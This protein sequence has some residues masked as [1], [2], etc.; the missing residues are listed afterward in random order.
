MRGQL[1]KLLFSFTIILLFLGSLL[2]TLVWYTYN[3][4]DVVVY[5]PPPQ[6]KGGAQPSGSC[7]GCREL[8]DK[9][10]KRYSIPWKK[11]ENNHQKFRTRLRNSC[12]GFEKAIITQAN[13]PVGTKINYDGEKKRS[14]QVTPE[15]FKTFIKDHPFPNKTLDTCAVVGNGGILTNSSCGNQ[16]DSAQ[17][18]IR[19]NLPPLE[20][21]YEKHVGVKTDLVTANPSIFVEKYGSLMGRR[22]P[23]VESLR[24][25]GNSLLLLP[26]FSFGQ[27]TAVSMRAL[28]TIEDFE[29]PARPVSINPAYLQNLA[30]FWRSQGLREMRLST[31]VMMASLALEL[32]ANVH[33]YG[34]WPFGNHP[35]DLRVLTNH[36]YDDRKSK[37]KI[38]A[39]PVEFEFL[40]QLHSQGVLRL[41]LGDCQPGE[42]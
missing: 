27:N 41:H 24:S 9:V 15:I 29:S 31:G 8:V 11:Q 6:R 37:T 7:K 36:Y 12:Q 23:F 22:R 14:I 13:T 34:F 40:L 18:V 39:M 25:Y 32:C 30:S 33:L 4:N 2:S 3:S 5:Q 42:K 26:T 19:C 16:I 38:H 21:G 35:H 17:F 10:I 20:N 28:Y 1:L